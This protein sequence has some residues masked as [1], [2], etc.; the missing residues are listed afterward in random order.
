MIVM[1]QLQGLTKQ[2]FM[3][4]YL[5]N[6]LFPCQSD[7]MRLVRSK[8]REWKF[9]DKFEYRMLLAVTNT[10]GTINSQVFQQNVSLSRQGQLEYGIYRATYGT[11]TDGFDVDMM[12]NL[13]TKEKTAA[14]ELDYATRMHSARTNLASLTKNFGIH[15]QYGVLH[16]LRESIGAP[17]ISPAYNPVPNVFAAPVIGQPFTIAAPVNVFSSNFKQGRTLIKTTENHYDGHAWVS[18]LYLVLENQV[19]FLTLMAIGTRTTDWRSGEF[20]QVANNREIIG[21]P[22]NPFGPSNWAYGAINVAT[23]PYQGIYDQYTGGGMGGAGDQVYT[24]GATSIVGAMEGLA[25]MFPWYTDPA[26]IETRLGLDRPYRDQPNRLRYSAEQA[27]GF[28]VQRPGENIIDAIMRGVI[29][30]K[31]M[32]SYTETGVWINEVTLQQMGYEEGESVRVIRDNF[33]A[34]PIIYQRGVETANYQIGNSVIK[35][36]V[37]DMNMPTDVII[38]GPQNDMSYNC[39]DNAT[40]EIDRYI[41]ESFGKSPPPRIEDLAI[42][43]EFLSKLDISNRITFGAPTLRDGKLA[44]FTHGNGIRHPRNMMPIAMHEMG[45]FFTEY[46]HYYTVVKLREPIVEVR[47]V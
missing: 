30:T 43:D 31:S 29:L 38:I 27:G 19:G 28:I 36:V 24:N 14:F 21:M 35:H 42:P 45:A 11:V 41:H 23:G 13:D 3:L 46:P 12:L 8:K 39:W 44:S 10:G 6:G 2:V 15:G 9:N 20:L 47:T 26:A 7:V 40:M 32:V 17:M 4:E 33:V 16:Q 5:V 25:D 1:D 37:R 18:E 34:G 22:E